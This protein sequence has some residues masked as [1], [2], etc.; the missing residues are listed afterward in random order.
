MTQNSSKTS[1]DVAEAHHSLSQ[2]LA[3]IYGLRPLEGLGARPYS[4]ESLQKEWVNDIN[5]KSRSEKESEE[6]A[7]AL[8]AL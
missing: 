3:N 4:P 7:N 1:V 5:N 8:K 2:E 6:E